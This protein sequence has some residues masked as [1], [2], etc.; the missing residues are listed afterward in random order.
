MKEKPRKIRAGLSRR[1]C[2]WGLGRGAPRLTR[3]VNVRRFPSFLLF[4]FGKKF[5]ELHRQFPQAGWC[6]AGASPEAVV[7]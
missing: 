6:D 3:P 4:L 7:A 2:V 1:G 5:G